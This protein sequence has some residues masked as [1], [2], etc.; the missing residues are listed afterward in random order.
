MAHNVLIVTT[1]A[2]AEADLARQL[3]GVIDE[4]TRVRVVAPAAKLS[5]LDWLTSDEDRARAE[6]RRAADRTAEAIGG[7]ADV[8]IDRASHDSDV[9][10]AVEDALRSFPADEIVVL[11]RPDEDA[12]WFEEEAVRA[13][14]ERFGVPVKHIELPED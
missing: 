2:A 9:A 11:T 8:R 5:W 7:E 13:S 10:Q 4:G 12:S 3:R 14:F 6:A 1:S